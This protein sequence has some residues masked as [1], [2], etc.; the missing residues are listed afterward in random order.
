[1]LF[2]FKFNWW[3]VFSYSSG[4]AQDRGLLLKGQ[5]SSAALSCSV[6]FSS[7]VLFYTLC[8]LTKQIAQRT[9]WPEAAAV[10]FTEPTS[11]SVHSL[12]YLG[13]LSLLALAQSSALKAI[14]GQHSV[15]QGCSSQFVKGIFQASSACRHWS[16]FRHWSYDTGRHN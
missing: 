3:S 11:L 12:L 4:V 15:L 10:Q 9:V 6:Q 1:M 2:F 13:I 14:A 5:V 8:Q 7:V 16:S